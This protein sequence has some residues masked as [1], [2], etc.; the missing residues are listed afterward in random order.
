MNHALKLLSAAL[1]A[2]LTFSAAAQ[3][4]LQRQLDSIDLGVQGVGEF[5]KTVS[6][7]VTIPANTNA[8]GTIVTQ[9]A[10]NTLGAL[11]TI[12]Y[13]PKPYVGLEF[14]GGYA[15]Y[16]EGFTVAPF[17]VQTQ[18]NELTVGYVVTPPYRIFGVKPFASAG[19]GAVRFAPTRGGGQGEFSIGRPAF[20]YNVGV[21][22]EV[23][24][25]HFGLRVGFRQVFYTAPDFYANYLTLNKRTVTSEPLIGFY[26][27][28]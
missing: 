1:V 5:T 15:R 28:F 17:Q 26:L 14:N 25:D 21:Q 18:V 8:A 12:R 23:F 9:D 20:Y 7:P 6:G 4:K 27:R 24:G 3:T 19:G 13:T 2:G 10:S 11:V 22:K 16:T